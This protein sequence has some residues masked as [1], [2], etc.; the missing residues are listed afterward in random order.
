M[1]ALQLAA[2]KLRAEE[3]S[4]DKEQPAM[5]AYCAQVRMTVHVI[6]GS[7]VMRHKTRSSMCVCTLYVTA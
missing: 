3:E 4:Q 5:P 2:A 1:G 6:R 7:Q